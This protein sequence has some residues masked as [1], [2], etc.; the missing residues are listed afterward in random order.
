M[1]TNNAQNCHILNRLESVRGAVL[2]LVNAGMTVTFVQIEGA[3][4][5][6]DLLRAPGRRHSLPISGARSCT[7][8]DENGCRIT[9]ESA[10]INGCEIRWRKFQ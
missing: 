3:I 1:S 10:S 9:E 6:I 2:M 7:R 5:R 8:L 4:P